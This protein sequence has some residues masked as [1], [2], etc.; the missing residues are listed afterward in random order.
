MKQLM[1]PASLLPVL[2]LKGG[3]GEILHYY[4]SGGVNNGYELPQTKINTQTVAAAAR[5]TAW[6]CCHSLAGTA[7]SNPAGGT[8]V[9][10][11]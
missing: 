8:D 1:V 2:S 9:C 11:L 5:S 3:D 4:R 10:L 6:A 7:G